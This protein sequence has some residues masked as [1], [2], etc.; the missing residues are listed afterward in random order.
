ME[1][2]KFIAAFSIAL[3][4]SF[5]AVE[6]LSLAYQAPEASGLSCTSSSQC[7]SLIEKKCGKAPLDF[8]NGEYY[9]CQSE[10]YS[11]EDYKRCNLEAV[12]A[13]ETCQK[14]LAVQYQNYQLISFLLYGLVGILFIVGGFIFLGYRSIGSGL[15]LSGVFVILF[16]G[17]ISLFSAIT[18]YSTLFR[19]LIGGSE[20]ISPQTFQL[21]RTL[22]YFVVSVLLIVM[23]YFRLDRPGLKSE[24]Y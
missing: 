15:L 17:Y 7:S 2:A 12:K 21:M 8:G 1:L 11:S 22:L 23:S 18:S 13:G 6:L 14:N 3:F 9:S 24:E 20:G 10:V 16:S 4:V 19:G 5:F